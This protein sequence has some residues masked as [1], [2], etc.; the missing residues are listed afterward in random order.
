MSELELLPR[1][2]YT[3][4]YTGPKGENYLLIINSRSERIMEATVYPGID[5]QGV[6][7]LLFTVLERED[8]PAPSLSVVA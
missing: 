6:I 3:A 4:P 7:D 2:I 8:P 5:P 1:G